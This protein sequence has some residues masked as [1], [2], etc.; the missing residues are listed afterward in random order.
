M[1]FSFLD[2]IEESPDHRCD[3]IISR[4]YRTLINCGFRKE[5]PISERDHITKCERP[6]THAYTVDGWDITS[7]RCNK[8]IIENSQAWR[9]LTLKEALV[10]EVLSA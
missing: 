5:S 3:A 9:R 1:R 7:Y 6:A 2:P 8:H 4:E 10:I